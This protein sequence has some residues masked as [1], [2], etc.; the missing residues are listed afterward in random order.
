MH[1]RNQWKATEKLKLFGTT[2]NTAKHYRKQTST[3]VTFNNSRLHYVVHTRTYT[4][5]SSMFGSIAYK[6]PSPEQFSDY[7]NAI[8]GMNCSA[9]VN[10]D[11][12]HVMTLFSDFSSM[13]QRVVY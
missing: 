3:A 12:D 9:N 6:L 13:M 10:T 2:T 1:V 7:P 8:A 5:M 4:C 11:F